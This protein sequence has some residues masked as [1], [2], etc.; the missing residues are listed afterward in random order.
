MSLM[1]NAD[2]KRLALQ[3]SADVRSGLYE[4]DMDLGKAEHFGESQELATAYE[5]R[6]RPILDAYVVRGLLTD[7][8]LSAL[9][10][11]GADREVLADRLQ[12]LAE[13]LAD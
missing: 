1:R 3:L 9:R 6:A 10:I 11:V 5:A 13:S 7:E 4:P 12:V 2:M 8:E